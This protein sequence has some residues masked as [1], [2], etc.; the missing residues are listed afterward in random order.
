ME[1]NF[2]SHVSDHH[3]YFLQELEEM[4]NSTE[5]EELKKL[6]EEKFNLIV[7]LIDKVIREAAKKNLF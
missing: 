7:Q 3:G 1:K 5:E 2:F 4:K 6:E